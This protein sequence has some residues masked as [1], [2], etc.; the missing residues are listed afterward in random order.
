MSLGLKF[1]PVF[2]I[3]PMLQVKA[4]YEWDM[5]FGGTAETKRTTTLVGVSSTST[6]NPDIIWAPAKSSDIGS[7]EVAVL[8]THNLLLG[9]AFEILPNLAITLQG[10]FALT[11]SVP[12]YKANGDLDG[13]ASSN[14]NIMAH[15]VAVGI[16][17]GGF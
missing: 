7:S 10:K 9:A 4:G 11:G 17:L 2:Q 5:P 15:Q 6:S 1:Q 13:A 3:G 14:S 8:S 12:H 16:Q